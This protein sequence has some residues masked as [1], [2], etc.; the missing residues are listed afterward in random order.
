VTIDAVSLDVTGGVLGC[1]SNV[2]RITVQ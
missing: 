1:V 2:A